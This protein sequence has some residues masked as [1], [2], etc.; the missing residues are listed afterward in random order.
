MPQH[1]PDVRPDSR[2]GRP[3][4][5][6]LPNESRG[7]G[8]TATVPETADIYQVMPPLSAEEYAALKA[9]IAEHGI[10]VSVVRDQH[11]HL[12]DG[13]HR[14]QIAEE[15]GIDCPSE[16]RHVADHDQARDIALTLNLA[17]RHLNREQKRALIA[18]EIQARPDDSDRAIG[19]R[20][21]CSPSTVG[22]V[23]RV[24]AGV[25]VGHPEFVSGPHARPT[26]RAQDRAD[27]VRSWI[28]EIDQTVIYLLSNRIDKFTVAGWLQDGLAE[29]ERRCPDREFIEPMRRHI[30]Y[31][32]IQ[33]ILARG[34]EMTEQYAGPDV[35]RKPLTDEELDDLRRKLGGR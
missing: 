26:Q 17:R 19:R 5:D 4:Q 2:K 15:L 9:D 16:V 1:D 21:G 14:V 31:P 30:Y 8:D 3:R 12:L 28:E 7:N 11:G 18:G 27:R 25:Q 24:L 35:C 32:R 6:D 34:D 13:H 10:L 23:R 33:Q 29:L 20:F 22:T